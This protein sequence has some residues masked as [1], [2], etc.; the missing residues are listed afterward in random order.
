MESTE[1][2]ERIPAVAEARRAA[3]A[4]AGPAWTLF[5]RESDEARWGEVRLGSYEQGRRL[6]LELSQLGFVVAVEDQKG[7]MRLRMWPPTPY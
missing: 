2:L 1:A 5:A 7:Q 3:G 4:L 6:A